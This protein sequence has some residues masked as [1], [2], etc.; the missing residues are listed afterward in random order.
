MSVVLDL[1]LDFSLPIEQKLRK[2]N[3]IIGL[4]RR[5]SICLRRKALPTIYKSFVRP[6]L[7]YGDTWYDKLG[8]LNFESKI[9]KAQY[10]ACIQGTRDIQGICREQLYDELGLMSLSKILW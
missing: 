3:K 10:K 1:K 6:H 2:C 8:N 9:E 7:D 4:I 5:L